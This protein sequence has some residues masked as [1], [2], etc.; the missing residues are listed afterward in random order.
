MAA[1]LI[2]TTEGS[3]KNI[4]SWQ[5][6]IGANTV[7]RQVV[8][9]GEQHLSDYIVN[10]G[11]G[12]VSSATANSHLLQCMAG[13]TLKVR[14]RRVELWQIGLATTAA[15]CQFTIVRLS[16]AGT[17]GTSLTPAPRDPA[18]SASGAT[19]MTLPTVKGTETTILDNGTA[20]FL[21]TAGASTTPLVPLWAKNYDGPRDQP[22]IVAAGA[23]NGFALKNITAIAAATVLPVFYV[24]ESNF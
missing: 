16:T 7:E 12:T 10:S 17:G 20:Y 3:G 6:V 22:I 5:W 1:S 18:A 8:A 15:F 19:G 14:L 23:A 2:A 4:E 24:T 13:S 11:A 9:L 21:Q